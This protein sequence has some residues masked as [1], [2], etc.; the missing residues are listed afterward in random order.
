MG[1]GELVARCEEA[2]LQCSFN[3][4][5]LSRG[6]LRTRCYFFKA[7]ANSHSVSGSLFT[8]GGTQIWP[9]VFRCSM[10]LSDFHLPGA[11]WGWV[12]VEQASY[13][14]ADRW[15]LYVSTLPLV[16]A[17]FRCFSGTGYALTYLQRL[18]LLPTT[19]LAEG[20]S[21]GIWVSACPLC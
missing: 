12:P 14:W 3:K 19:P 20:R 5:P 6:I 15:F 9:R 16:G 13:T 21:P 4:W 11:K 7:W 2:I 18:P 8:G 10:S 17:K 1:A